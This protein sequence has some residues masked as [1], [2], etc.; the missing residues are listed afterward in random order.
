MARTMLQQ[1]AR[2]FARTAIALSVN[3][4]CGGPWPPFADS[5]LSQRRHVGHVYGLP[6]AMF[7][8]SCDSWLLLLLLLPTPAPIVVQ[9][10]PGLLLL[11]V[12]EPFSA[13]SC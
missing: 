9:P 4:I 5:S 8:S 10:D 1:V 6:A 3:Y 11:L 2:A 13:L 12:C 7:A